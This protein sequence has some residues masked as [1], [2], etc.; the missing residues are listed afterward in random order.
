MVIICRICGKEFEGAFRQRA[1]CPECKEKHGV[2]GPGDCSICKTYNNK[3]DQNARGIDVC[4]CSS[5]WFQ[6]H[7]STPEMK[8]QAAKVFKDFYATEKGKKWLIEHNQSPKMRQQAKRA[9]LLYGPI[10]MNKYNYSDLHKEKVKEFIGPGICSSCGEFAEKRNVS[11]RCKKCSSIKPNFITKD[12][13][14][15]YKGIEINQFVKKIKSGELNIEDYPGMN[16]RDDRLCYHTEDILTGD[17]IKLSNSNFYEINNVRYYKGIEVNEFASKVLSGELNIKE[18]PGMNI[19]CSRVCYET[20]DIITSNKILMNNNFVEL[21]GVKF[22]KNIEINELIRQLDAGEISVP[23]GFNKRFGRWHYNAED[24]ITGEIT[25]L[26][27]SN[28]E[29]RN[30][31]LYY[32]DKSEDIQD[33]IPWEEYKEKFKTFNIDFKLP[34]GFKICSTFRTQDSESWEGTKGA[35]EQSLVENNVTWFV[36]IKFDELNHPLVAGKSG[37][38]L[39][40]SRGSDVSF[41]TRIEDGPARRFLQENNLNWCKTQI[42]IC[43]CKTEQEAFELE[44]KIQKEFNLFGG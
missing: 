20:E 4:Q 8:A 26:N 33:Y 42:A 18:Y 13:V 43:P 6:K 25:K 27:G 34:K 15:Y 1:I 31:I 22:Y 12:S 39:V 40:N 19:R 17:I 2:G 29:E 41:S 36:Y 44:E 24:I 16:W 23:P 38:Y 28:F 11:Q 30:D 14:R 7:N 9:G 3:R 10:N 37:S 32:Y 21:D 5:K 35:F